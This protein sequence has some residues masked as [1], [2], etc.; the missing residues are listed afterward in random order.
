MQLQTRPQFYL[1][2]AEEVEY[3]VTKA[4]PETAVRWSEA[5]DKTIQAIQTH[6]NLGR[7]R[8][9]LRPQALRSRRMEK[10]RRWLV[11]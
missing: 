8:N 7:L 4:G 1:D 11:F 9:D 6:P 2:V 3:L 5:L 10:F